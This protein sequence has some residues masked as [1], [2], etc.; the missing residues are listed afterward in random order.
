MKFDKIFENIF[1]D[2]D[3]L[4][5][6]IEEL[7]TTKEKGDAFEQYAYAYFVFFKD[8]YQIKEHFM[9]QDIPEK[10]REICHR[11][12]ENICRYRPGHRRQA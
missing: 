8:K 3:E 11:C 6:K 12:P 1:Q 10:Y 7:P 4:E 5:A 2:W 9:W